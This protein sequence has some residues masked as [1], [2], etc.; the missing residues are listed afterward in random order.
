MAV[1]GAEV[2]IGL[3]KQ[4]AKGTAQATAADIFKMRHLNFQL[5]GNRLINRGQAEIGGELLSGNDPVVLGARP[6]FSGDGE[7]RLGSIGKWLRAVGFNAGTVGDGS[8]AGQITHVFSPATTASN[9]LWPYHTL[10]IRFGSA[11]NVSLRDSRLANLE[12]DVQPGQPLTFRYAGAGILLGDSAAASHTEE[13]AVARVKPSPAAG[14]IT[15]LLG[16]AGTVTTLSFGML[17]EGNLDTENQE[18]TTL[19]IAD[20]TPTRLVV[21][22][23]GSSLLDSTNYKK[24]E[25]GAAAGT[26]A[27]AALLTGA[28]DVRFD[29]PDDLTGFA[30]NK[31]HVLFHSDNCRYII[32]QGGVRATPDR[33][34]LIPWSAYP[35]TAAVNV[36]L[37]NGA[38]GTATGLDY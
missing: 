1:G 34:V 10:D 27:T 7:L 23:R 24:L 12:F 33:Q 31:G 21:T 25:Y 9:A 6:N 20:V 22:Y 26:V 30:G 14:A 5:D 17:I 29:T 38:D 37:K 28:L 36:T 35:T 15:N 18:L 32:D 13:P 11:I 19:F 2:S 3:G 16:V 8:G 4:T